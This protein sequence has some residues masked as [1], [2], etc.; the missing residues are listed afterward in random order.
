MSGDLRISGGAP[1]PTGFTL[2]DPHNQPHPLRGSSIT[3]ICPD[4]SRII[5]QTNSVVTGVK[6]AV[7]N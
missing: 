7:R 2:S 3:Q 6:T 1:P 4:K 5:R